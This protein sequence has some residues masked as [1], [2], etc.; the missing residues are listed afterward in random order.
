M[1]SQ[2]STCSPESNQFKIP[3][4]LVKMK[5]HHS[6]GCFTKTTLRHWH[7]RCRYSF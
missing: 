7:W 2:M 5:Y 4:V 1:Y 3:I 6:L